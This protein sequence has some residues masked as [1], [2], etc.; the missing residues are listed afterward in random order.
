MCVKEV[1]AKEE[2]KVHLC[3]SQMA[4]KEG[5]GED[6]NTSS[7]FLEEDRVESDCRASSS[8]GV[9]L[10]EDNSSTVCNKACRHKVEACWSWICLELASLSNS[11]SYECMELLYSTEMK[12]IC[13][14]FR[15]LFVDK[16]A[17]HPMPIMCWSGAPSSTAR[18]YA[19]RASK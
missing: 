3:R 2:C 16:A 9:D 10:W 4:Y 13:F 1:C 19:L 6:S 5:E 11:S 15:T 12:H 18:S 14:P 17:V 7:G 8:F